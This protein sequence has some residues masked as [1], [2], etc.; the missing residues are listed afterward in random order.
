MTIINAKIYTMFGQ[1][2]ENGYIEIEGKKISEIGNMRNFSGSGE[3]NANGALVFPGFID[4]HTHMG[5][6][7]EGQVYETDDA[8]EIGDTI[9]PHLRVIDAI[10]PFDR[11][12]SDALRAGITSVVVSPGSANSISGQVSAIKTYGVCI[13]DMVIKSPIAMKFSLG[14]NPKS[15]GEKDVPKTRMAIAAGIREA[16]RKAEKCIKDLEENP[17][18][19]DFDIKN[20]ALIDFLKSKA[21]AQFHA[22][23]ACDIFT[24]MR[25][26]HEFNLKFH[27]IHGTE[28]YKI[29]EYLKKSNAGVF[30]GPIITDRSKPEILNFDLKYIKIL[31]EA[32][33]EISIT[34]DH[35]VIP[36]Q[37][38]PLCASIA[39]ANGLGWEAALHSITSVPAKLC[40]ISDVVGTLEVGKDADIIVFNDDPLKV[41]VTPQ[42]VICDGKVVVDNFNKGL[43]YG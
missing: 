14:E 10:N 37:H 7:E 27:I 8:N 20:Q 19:N 9:T 32:G 11:Y 39:A 21:P 31:H 43:I 40:G 42:L 33:I 23:R 6:F 34:T 12:F 17:N 13:D 15:T 3:F 29:A 18:D 35:P 16:L 5:L 1:H 28:S 2:F 36:I 26:A 4:C 24:A 38:L 22:H 25:L 41:G 30:V